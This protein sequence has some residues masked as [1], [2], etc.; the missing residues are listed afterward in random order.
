MKHRTSV[1]AVIAM[2]SSGAVAS[3][4]SQS[5]SDDL[6]K[7]AGERLSALQQESDA[8][9][10]RERTLLVDL[11][12]LE[13]DRQ[14]KIERLASIEHDSAQVQS[15]LA[16]AEQ[17]AATLAA[18]VESE[19]PDVEARFVQ[20]YKLGRVGYWRMLLDVDSLRE[21]GR[22]YRTA[23]A[24]GH[25]DRERLEQH[26]RNVAALDAE[27]ATLRQRVTELAQ[28]Q[29]QAETARASAAR[30]VAAQ[31]ALVKSI[32]ERRDLNAQL[33]G[34]LQQARDRLQS[35]VERMQAGT[36]RAAGLP[37]RPFRGVLPWPADGIPIQ[38]AHRGASAAT[39]KGIELS[40]PAGQPVKSVHEGTVAFADQ[41]T[42]YGNLVIVDHGD[43]DFSL[44]GNLQALAVHKGD[45]VKAGSTVGSSGRDPAGNPS[46]YFELR[47]DGQPVDPLQWLKRS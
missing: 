18:E 7:R 42:G 5:Q 2:L 36:S 19:R 39:R 20:L 30:A 11:R 29:Q 35:E 24:L 43:N 25:I 15:Q 14:I 32:D 8:L 16:D 44:Y 6:S 38:R 1:V 33:T 9:A 45:R 40:L 41:F 23:S 3:G 17:R 21:L 47:I 4:T 12:K 28:L 22:A 46:L 27:R 13:L 34:E 37:I 10:T 31:T 26:R